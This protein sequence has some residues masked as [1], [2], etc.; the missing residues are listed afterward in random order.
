MSRA[1]DQRRP[2]PAATEE[3]TPLHQLRSERDELRNELKNVRAELE[4]QLRAQSDELETLLEERRLLQQELA[5]KDEYIAS[6]REIDGR[7]VAIEAVAPAARYRAVDAINNQLLRVR[8]LHSAL[9]WLARK[10]F[11][12]GSSGA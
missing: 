5:V 7:I 4:S 2:R 1:D 3:A 6:L 10:I 12:R 8:P 11:P 9:R